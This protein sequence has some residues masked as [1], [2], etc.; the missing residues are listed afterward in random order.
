MDLRV[1]QSCLNSLEQSASE[2]NVLLIDTGVK[3][4]TEEIGFVIYAWSSLKTPS[5]DDSVCVQ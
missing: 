3:C 1:V 4:V 5:K 2:M